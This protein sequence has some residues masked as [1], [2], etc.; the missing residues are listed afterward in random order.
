ME[1]TLDHV[2]LNFSKDSLLLLNACIAI[3]MFG[4]A[5]ELKLESF[6][7][8]FKAPKPIL[9]GLASQL[10]LL[11]FF[12]FLM[13]LVIE[14]APSIALGLMLVSSCPGGNVSNFYSSISKANVALSV[15]LTAITSSLSFLVTPLNFSIWSSFYEPTAQIIEKVHLNI[16]DVILNMITILVIPLIAG[17]T[18]RHK[19]PNTTQK[20]YKP[21]KRLSIVLF[22]SFVVFALKANFGYFLEYIHYILF[23]VFAHNLMALCIGFFSAT[24]AKLDQQDRRSVTIETGIQNSG[25]ALVIIFDYFNGLGGMAFI[26][27]WWGVWHLLSGA[28]VSWLWS[29]KPT[30]VPA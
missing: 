11:P 23:I 21:I 18:F 4:V 2:V 17:M 7:L 10:I 3:I 24:A 16:W 12:T 27:A 15:S 1:E 29:K 8:L 19:L 26:A 9:V 30:E 20:I 25:L 5:L 28:A 22:G 6:K 13:V 14:P